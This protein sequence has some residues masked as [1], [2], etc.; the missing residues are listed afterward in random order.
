MRVALA[1]EYDG[2]AYCGWQRQPHSPS[3]QAEVEAALSRI[4]NEPITVHCSGRTDTGV[5]A[6]A[7]IVHFDTTSTRELTAWTYG[8]NSVLARD[9]S[10]HW[11]S[12]MPDDFHAR[13][14]ADS[15]S[16]QYTILNRPTRPGLD[17][18]RLSWQ[19]D[20][21]DVDRMQLAAKHLLGEHDFSSFRSSE[22][23]AN[24]PIRVIRDLT[25][26][27]TDD[28]V[29]I[30]IT[31]NGFLHNMV[32]IIAGSLMAIGTG[33]QSTGW[34]QEL[35]IAK[36]RTQA[37]MTAPPNGLVFVQAHYPKRFAVPTFPHGK[38]VD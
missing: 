21:L 26:T 10:I 3:V 35:L 28:R 14:S 7:Q 17:A 32:R 23:Q 8:A 16:Y 6:I 2:Q 33:D 24:H 37:A 31:A 18:K 9:V 4:A 25:V 20:P 27:R 36:D 11:A 30:N 1:V 34:L 12:A 15:R 29:I 22:C 38:R 5:H 19:R 13:F